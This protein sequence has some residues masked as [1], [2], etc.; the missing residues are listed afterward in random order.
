VPHAQWLLGGPTVPAHG[1]AIARR[2]SP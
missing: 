2:R 1:L